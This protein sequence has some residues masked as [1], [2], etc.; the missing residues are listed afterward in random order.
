M[1]EPPDLPDDRIVAAVQ[2][3]YGLHLTTLTFLPLGQD[4]RAWA[5]RAAT[6]DGA[7]YFLKLRQRAVRPASLRVPRY[8][9]D[10]GVPHVVAPLPTRAQRLW[11]DVEGFTLALYPFISGTT[12]GAHGLQEHHWVTYGAALRAMHN[13]PLVPDLA[14]DVPHESFTSPCT[15]VVKALEAHIPTQGDTDPIARD[16]A[17]LWQLKRAE[18]QTLVTRLETL[19]QRLRVQRPALVLCHADVHH[20]NILIDTEDQFWI[21]DWDDTRLAPKE[22]DLMMGVGGLGGAV[23]GP[24]EEAW[25]LRGYGL[26]TIDPVALAYYRH[27]RAVG[28]IAEYGEQVWLLP[29][30]SE[31]TKRNALQRT[32]RAFAPGN[33]VA[34]ANQLERFAT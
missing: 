16:L 15:A 24:R 32:M 12:G 29:D 5:F 10:Q 6:T 30:V 9:A 34:L 18:L 2:Q 8:L 31:A 13:T 21:V 20:N 1:L 19:G 27:L 26:T 33:I 14:Q 7:I 11:T 4:V 25:F 17:A 28:D 3:H 23:V 22:C